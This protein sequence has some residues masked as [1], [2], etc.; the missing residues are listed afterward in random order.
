MGP[1]SDFPEP[2]KEACQAR[3]IRAA[4]DLRGARPALRLDVRNAISCHRL[5]PEQIFRCNF[6]AAGFLKYFL[7]FFLTEAFSIL[8]WATASGLGFQFQALCGW[9]TS[10]NQD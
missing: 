2:E 10:E 5:T 7:F 1:V 3:M 8:N 9:I 6:T 4:E